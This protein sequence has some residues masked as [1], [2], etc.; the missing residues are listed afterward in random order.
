MAISHLT[1]LQQLKSLEY[2]TNEDGMCYGFASCSALAFLARDIKTYNKRLDLL[3]TI[4]PEALPERIETV[5]DKVKA[6]HPLTE[7]ETLL[8]T[9]PAF[10][11]GVAITYQPREYR[12]FFSSEQMPSVQNLRQTL[13]LVTPINLEE[14][15]SQANIAFLPSFSGIYTQEEVKIYFNLLQTYFNQEIPIS[16]QLV[17][18]NHAITIGFDVETK[19]WMMVNSSQTIPIHS[20]DDFVEKLFEAFPNAIN[21][22]IAFSTQMLINQSNHEKVKPAFEAFQQTSSY[23]TLHTV[24]NEKAKRVDSTNAGWLYIASQN[25]HTDTVKQLLAQTNVDIN[26]KTN[27][28]FTP[29]HLA[30]QFGHKKI[31]KLLLQHPNI[32]P[33][34][35]NNDGMTPLM[36]AIRAKSIDSIHALL[37]HPNIKP[38]EKGF[39]DLTALHGAVL[40]KNIEV[41]QT[42][43]QHPK[44][45]PNVKQD[46]GE[47]PLYIAAK[48]EQI[49]IVKMLLQHPKTKPNEKG[50]DGVTALHA[51][52]EQ[53]DLNTIKA[54]LLNPNTNPNKKDQNTLAPLHLATQLNHI[55]ALNALLEH[56]NINPNKK[57]EHGITPLHIA[58]ENGLFDIVNI[59]LNHKN[60]NPNKKDNNGLTPLHIATKKGHIE[61]VK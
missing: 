47:T 48:N 14:P 11:D 29:L 2:K 37:R 31:I 60:I 16:L 58:C 22:P 15:N 7:E 26:Q 30:A 27:K 13:P 46:D 20:A 52:V 59:L 12:E 28:G 32:K 34:E 8:N 35:K 10:F 43:I 33:N 9:I 39:N 54:L 50:E 6:K 38:N 41:V 51:A 1:L 23:Q 18:S 17:S 4:E 42:L 45:N 5:R 3:E 61:I 21:L 40:V 55:E 44:I 57:N 56:K 49:D 25:K 53:E 19:S 36:S 24:T